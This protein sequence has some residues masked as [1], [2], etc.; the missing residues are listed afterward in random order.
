MV[1]LPLPAGHFCVR[2]L[3]IFGTDADA[4]EL[5]L[6]RFHLVME[7]I[8]IG[9]HEFAQGVQR[10]LCIVPI[11]RTVI[12]SPCRTPSE[13]TAM[14]LSALACLPRSRT[15]MVDWKRPAVCTKRLAGRAWRPAGLVNVSCTSSAFVAGGWSA[16]AGRSHQWR[17]MILHPVRGA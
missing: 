4:A 17:R 8:K 13:R 1:R 10:G 3:D 2:T 9:V 14:M 15:C 7:F 5:S 6:H 16:I 11:A 12:V